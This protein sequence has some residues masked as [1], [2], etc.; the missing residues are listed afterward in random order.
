MRSAILFL[1]LLAASACAQYAGVDI[2]LN[3]LTTP[4]SVAPAL[5]FL[6]GQ[7]WT[8]NVDSAGAGVFLIQDL[9][10]NDLFL[11]NT[12]TDA[13]VFG[14]ATTNPTYS[15][16]GTGAF[17]LAGSLA[18]N[19]VVTIGD[20]GDTVAVNSSDWDIS[21]TGAMTGIGAITM[22][23]T[24]TLANSET[25]ANGTNGTLTFGRN[26]AGVVTVTAADDDATAALTILPG[27]AAA[28]ILGGASTTSVA[29]TSDG[30]TVTIDGSISGA[31]TFA[32]TGDDTW[33]ATTP[34]ITIT[35]GETVAISDG[36][37][38]LFSVADSGTTGTVTTGGL[39]AQSLTGTSPA[40][41]GGA[42]L[43]VLVKRAVAGTGTDAETLSIAE[44]FNGIFVQTPTGAT[45]C[46]TPTGTEIS[47]GL[48]G[49]AVGDSFE[50]TLVNLGITTRTVT[51]TAGASGVTIIGNAIAYSDADVAT[52]GASSA[53]FVFVNT[54]SNT[55]IAYRR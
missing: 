9:A 47:A 53:T 18:L 49:L 25:V 26:D 33:T 35:N 45:T 24:L 2:P 8:W 17:S 38:T 50:F 30:G 13:V 37:N 28:F 31:T 20:G 36:S 46:T 12:D 29:L 10:G 43:P 54:A 1:V 3:K 4:K 27:G 5:N 48:T 7:S 41:R 21:T 11:I 23:G 42:D 14:N 39:V 6:S 16:A 15:F 22:D 19:G 40:V 51:L 55:W 32:H 52:A 34:T 44:L